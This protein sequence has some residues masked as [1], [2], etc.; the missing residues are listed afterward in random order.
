MASESPVPQALGSAGT[1]VRRREPGQ[2][3]GEGGG[4]GGKRAP[5]TG[6]ARIQF[7]PEGGQSTLKKA[8]KKSKRSK[9]DED[10]DEEMQFGAG[11]YNPLLAP[12]GRPTQP[13]SLQECQ[14][15]Q[16]VEGGEAY[17]EGRRGSTLLV[18][19]GGTGE[20]WSSIRHELR[21]SGFNSLV[22]HHHDRLLLALVALPVILTVV[23]FGFKEPDLQRREMRE[24]PSQTADLMLQASTVLLRLAEERYRAE[25]LQYFHI[26][27]TQ[28][29]ELQLENG[30]AFP[31][32]PSVFTPMYAHVSSDYD[33]AIR[34]TDDA[35]KVLWKSFL[36]L[37][38][39]GFSSS[40]PVDDLATFLD[41][42]LLELTRIQVRGGSMDQTNRQYLQVFVGLLTWVSRGSFSSLVVDPADSRATIMRGA[43]L[44]GRL[45]ANTVLTASLQRTKVN[46][47]TVPLTIPSWTAFL[48][49]MALGET[50]Q[51]AIIA[52]LA[53]SDSLIQPLS[54]STR[55]LMQTVLEAIDSSV[56]FRVSFTESA[57]ALRKKQWALLSQLAT[58]IS[59]DANHLK[60]SSEDEPKAQAAYA[61]LISALIL[62]GIILLLHFGFAVFNVKE[63]GKEREI[64]DLEKAMD[65]MKDFIVRLSHLDASILGS[66]V[67]RSAPH[68]ELLYRGF[69]QPMKDMIG[70]LPQTVGKPPLSIPKHD[71]TQDGLWIRAGP[72]YS[73][74]TMLIGLRFDITTFHKAFHAAGAKQRAV[75]HQAQYA[76]SRIA[77]LSQSMG[78]SLF[79]HG[80]HIMSYVNLSTA[81]LNPYGTALT[82]AFQTFQNAASDSSLNQV[83][84]AIAAAPA[85]LGL[86]RTRGGDVSRLTA[87]NIVGPLYN[88][89]EVA[90]CVGRLHKV[91]IVC[92]SDVADGYRIELGQAA[93]R[94]ASLWTDDK[95]LLD[96]ID[97]F[98]LELTETQIPSEY[99]FDEHLV[100][101]WENLVQSLPQRGAQVTLAKGERIVYQ[102]QQPN[103]N[104]SG[105]LPGMKKRSV[106]NLASSKK[107]SFRNDPIKVEW[108]SVF[109]LYS[110]A[111]QS[112]KEREE[113]LHSLEKYE[114]RFGSTATTQRLRQVT[115]RKAES[116]ESLTAPSPSRVTSLNDLRYASLLKEL[117]TE[118][119]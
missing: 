68:Q 102:P 27:E 15:G 114:E 36:K 23:Y 60:Q 96:D 41:E 87:L 86:A 6:P 94:A 57:V 69:L 106:T 38:R 104:A 67:P 17:A 40:S 43:G 5:S 9:R 91:K 22:V 28:Q 29:E 84:V 65:R 99:E 79:V 72:A 61:V 33:A 82:L 110:R 10:D 25:D 52:P 95:K 113:F 116:S 64:R 21:S 16:P 81:Q 108:D 2:Q 111:H 37:H 7:D 45:S 20:S 39:E 14:V 115:L 97:F 30:K 63:R 46:N 11:A 8:K 71:Q 119:P 42:S 83:K 18:E 35:K 80:D 31:Y 34:S 98:P 118:S 100:S 48:N 66:K 112:K 59:D 74:V 75:Q 89:L 56:F 58:S 53:S 50:T 109:E 103:T 85:Q 107:G 24:Q 77:E 51:S 32:Y 54:E 1:Q 12:S 3:P 105:L 26:S 88:E 70:F 49:A 78:C 93:H 92:T 76:L 55:R 117:F 19:D 47:V 44:I 13:R 90:N 62:A 101:D 4:G 73:Q